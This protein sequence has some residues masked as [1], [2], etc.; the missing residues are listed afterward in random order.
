MWYRVV[1]KDNVQK[2]NTAVPKASAGNNVFATPPIKTTH[3]VAMLDDAMSMAVDC[4]GVQ[5]GGSFIADTL[6]R[7]ERAAN[8]AAHAAAELDDERLRARDGWASC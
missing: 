1:S 7:L 4:D 2:T 3:I 8:L 5:H 6:N